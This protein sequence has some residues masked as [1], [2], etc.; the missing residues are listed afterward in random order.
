MATLTI[1]HRAVINRQEPDELVCR[2]ST[3]R[4]WMRRNGKEILSESTVARINPSTRRSH[5]DPRRTSGVLG[6]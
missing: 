1:S 4:I 6:R 3:A 5:D 2:R